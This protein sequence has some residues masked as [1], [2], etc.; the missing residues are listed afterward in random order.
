MEPAMNQT[1]LSEEERK[2]REERFRYV[3]LNHPL[4]QVLF[5]MQLSADKEPGAGQWD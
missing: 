3:D 5:N 2:K 4:M 1:T